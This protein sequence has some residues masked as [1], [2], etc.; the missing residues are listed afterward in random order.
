[1]DSHGNLFGT[2]TD[3]GANNR[4]TVFK[5]DSNGAYSLLYTFTGGADGSVP[6]RAGVVLDTAGNLY[7]VTNY[8]GTHGNGVI[9]KLTP[10]GQ[11]TVLYS[12]AGGNDGA[13]PLGTLVRDKA[14]NFYGVTNLGGANGNGTVFRLSATGQLSVI[15]SFGPGIDGEPLSGVVLDSLGNLYG[16]TTF[17]GTNH[18]G[19]IFKL[20]TSGTLTTLH[21]FSGG[22]DGGRPV[23]GVA[24]LTSNTRGVLYGTT[25]DGGTYSGGTVFELLP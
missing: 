14:G 1:L 7:G 4:G 9:Y 18:R 12:F 3:G 10:T 17:G 15:Y 2:T 21:S 25:V 19:S 24:G 13:N 8:G 6:Y 23:G 11:E 22:S 5:L 20:T 16:T